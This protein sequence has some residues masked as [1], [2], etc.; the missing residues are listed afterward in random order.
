MDRNGRLSVTEQVLSS[1]DPDRPVLL[2]DADEVLLRFVER[3]EVFFLSKGFELRLT[4]FRL[5]GNIYDLSTGQAAEQCQVKDMLKAFFNECV[6]D[7]IAVP[8]A[9]EAL[10]A[11]SDYYQIAVLSNVPANC[12]AR[13]E[14]NLAQLGISYPVI[15]NKGDKGPVVRRFMQAATSNK[16]IFIDDLP[17]QHSSVAEHC[18]GSHRIHFIGDPRLAKMINKAPDANIRIDDWHLITPHLIAFLEA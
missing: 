10:A 15:A 6:D 11:L 8:G 18:P 12:R 4:S 14:D 7:M 16:L 3:L 17:P 2:V 9:A 13:R 5:S 1:F